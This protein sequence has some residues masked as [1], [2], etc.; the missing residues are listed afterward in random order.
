LA[1]ALHPGLRLPGIWSA[2]EAGIRA[3]IGQQISVVAATG[4]LAKLIAHYGSSYCGDPADGPVNK[5]FPSP[6]RLAAETLGELKMPGARKQSLIDFSAL[7]SNQ[8]EQAFKADHW[9]AIKGVGPWTLNYARLR[10][11]SEP[12]IL[13]DG[14]LGIKK[15]IAQYHSQFKAEDAAPWRSYLNMQLWSLL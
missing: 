15:A 11:L 13:L 14:D 6:A 9:L 8:S 12:D 2:Y 1:K 3:I 7:Y 10:G 4:Q 5:L